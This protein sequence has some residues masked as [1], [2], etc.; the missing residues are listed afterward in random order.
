LFLFYNGDY[1]LCFNAKYKLV[2][3]VESVYGECPIYEGG[4][5]IVRETGVINLAET[6]AVCL[7]LL[8]TLIH[9]YMAK[10]HLDYW[11]SFGG[12]DYSNEKTKCPRAGPPHGEGYVIVSCEST[13]IKK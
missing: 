8:S 4:E 10:Q 2:A 7:Q 12:F 3:K 11:Q 5:Q 6:D 1:E 13:P 9:E